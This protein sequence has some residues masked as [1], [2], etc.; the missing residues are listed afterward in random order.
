MLTWGG[1]WYPLPAHLALLYS[2][3]IEPGVLQVGYYNL[4]HACNQRWFSNGLS[5][6]VTRRLDV[7]EKEDKG[8][9]PQL[10]PDLQ[11]LRHQTVLQDAT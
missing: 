5:W 8:A 3:S 4:S 1:S 10:C 9:N 11:S 6:G 2:N 7:Q